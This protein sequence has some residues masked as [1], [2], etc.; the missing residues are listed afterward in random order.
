MALTRRNMLLGSAALAAGVSVPAFA[1]ERI[2]RRQIPGTDD[3][4]PVV[5]LGNSN[6][7]RRGDVP[8]S[9][10]V[11]ER[12]Q[13]FGGRYVDC[14][15][16]SRFVVAEA[17]GNIGFDDIFP[18]AYFDLA[19]AGRAQREARS[20]MASLGRNQLDV[21]LCYTDQ[22][23]AHWDVLR[24]MKDDGLT[25]YIGTA[26]HT[27]V[28]YDTM[29]RLMETGTVDVLQVN[30]SLLEP[31]AEQRVLPVAA[32]RGVA[33]LTNRPFING[34]FFEL[35]RGRPLPEWAADFDCETWA[36]F[37]LKFILSHPAV[38]CVL[39]ETENPKHA[40]DNLRAGLGRL[41]DMSMRERMRAVIADLA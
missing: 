6:A 32:E 27:S 15:G 24:S 8:A 34:R 23:G 21:M 11:L 16:P 33:V 31:E 4:L 40:V 41:P 7:F 18:G 17:A 30:Y 12:L 1:D 29:I 26:R 3:S 38:T 22:V 13:G 5:G 14:N 36:Q 37:S 39:T 35:V 2:A 25:K 20:L 9:E 28:Y 10:A 19:D